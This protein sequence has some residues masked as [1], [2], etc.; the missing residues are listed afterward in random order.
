MSAWDDM[1]SEIGDVPQLD[2]AACKGQPAIFDL[3]RDSE[4]TAIEAAQAVCNSC[5]ALIRCR[6]WLRET[7]KHRRPSGVV[8]GR[9]L[10]P[11][12]LAAE[13]PAPAQRRVQPRPAAP[14]I[15]DRSADWLA[16]YLAGGT[17]PAADVKRAAK[18]AGFGINTL[19][20]AASRLDV[21]RVRI[22]QRELAWRLPET[23]CR[24]ARA[25]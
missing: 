12:L 24:L 4:P 19:H 21:L 8:A 6:A 17:I 3:D 7:S 23:S 2:G 5:P 25:Q 14:M 18:A 10:A 9:L 1:V 15:D 20:R 16:Q 11:P 13:K 22:G